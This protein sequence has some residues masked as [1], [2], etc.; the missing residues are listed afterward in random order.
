MLDKHDMEDFFTEVN[1][2]SAEIMALIEKRFEDEGYSGRQFKITTE[3][4]VDA[5]AKT[6]TKHTTDP[7]KLANELFVPNLLDRIKLFQ[8]SEVKH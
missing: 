5:L 7:E 3:A 6:L 4:L 1:D 8:S 2:I